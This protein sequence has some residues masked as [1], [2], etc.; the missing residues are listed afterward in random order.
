[1]F[2][3]KISLFSSTRELEHKIDLMHDK[4]IECAMYF[5][6]AIAIFLKE[7]RSSAYRRAKKSKTLNL[8]PMICA[9]KLKAAYMRKI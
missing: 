2:N 9:V 3:V 5:K 4:V 1:M 6:E 8:R 7:K